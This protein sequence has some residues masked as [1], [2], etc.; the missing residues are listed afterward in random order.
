MAQ[1]DQLPLF[2]QAYDLCLYLDQIVRT[3]PRYHKYALGADLR[4][5][6]RRVLRLVVWANSPRD[7]AQLFFLSFAIR[8][9]C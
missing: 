8:S 3:F 4:E 5:S 6:T 7:Q 1:T 9:R 2:K